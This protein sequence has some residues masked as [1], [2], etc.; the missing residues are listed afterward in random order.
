MVMTQVVGDHIASEVF[1]LISKLK[2]YERI[3]KMRPPLFQ[4]VRV[5]ILNEFLT[6]CHDILE[7]V[8]VMDA[9]SVGFV[10]LQLC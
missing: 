5:R 1:L 2:C 3:R 6:F 7:V 8:C 10:T 4:V 9:C